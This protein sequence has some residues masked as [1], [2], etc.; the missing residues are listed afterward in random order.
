M[1]D[2]LGNGGAGL[3]AYGAPRSQADEPSMVA[4][5][6]FAVAPGQ[7]NRDRFIE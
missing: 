1:D 4:W 2:P 5:H 7:L 6:D 3:Q